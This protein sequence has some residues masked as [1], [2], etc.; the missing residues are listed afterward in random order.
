MPLRSDVTQLTV[1]QSIQ[2]C[3]DQFEVG[4][5][6]TWPFEQRASLDAATVWTGLLDEEGDP[7]Y[8]KH[9]ADGVIDEID[10]QAS[11]RQMVSVIRG[12]DA[13]AVA[14][15]TTFYIE[16]GGPPDT[17]T[18]TSEGALAPIPGVTTVLRLPGKWFASAI[19]RDL[20]QRIGLDL[21]W[22]VP[23]YELKVPFSVSGPVINALQELAAPFSQFEPSRVDVWVEGKTLIMRSR[24]GLIDSPAEGATP[25]QTFTIQSLMS[26]SLHLRHSTL[27]QTRVLRLTGAG[28]GGGICQSI[29][30]DSI[31]TLF[32]DSTG[33]FITTRIVERTTR[34]DP[35]GAILKV[36][37]ETY[38]QTPGAEGQEALQTLRL[39]GLY[40][41]IA[42]WDTLFFDEDCNLLNTPREHGQKITIE[43]IDPDETISSLQ[44][45][46]EH[47]V[48][49]SYDENGFRTGQVTEKF[50][51]NKEESRFDPLAKEVTR[52]QPKGILEYEQIT[53]NYTAGENDWTLASS[54]KSPA[55]GHLP[56]GPGRA[57]PNNV[58][59]RNPAFVAEIIDN[60]PGARDFTYSNPNL[61][62]SQLAI[63]RQQAVDASGA[64]ELEVTFRASGIPWLRKG[65][66]IRIK[67]L[68]N[69]DNDEILEAPLDTFL[70][71]A[72]KI[73]LVESRDGSSYVSQVTAVN[74]SGA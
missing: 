32:F 33:S 67:G 48:T 19:A 6:G 47:T 43:A 55:G 69:P 59:S 41:M 68:R 7:Q 15:D 49:F 27:P 36:V 1:D 74:W 46:E 52:L 8:V 60:V 28:Q 71:T 65:Q 34:R 39:S 58:L 45:V 13:S 57:L 4:I 5:A 18:P 35:D 66:R 64:L 12:R 3:A 50:V 51:W 14:I 61:T 21:S 25:V 11:S 2:L 16:Y 70:V 56:A 42:N 24:A 31:E 38:T 73:T 53:D 30:E 63:I 26:Q 37:K 10:L 20:T 17:S 29:S 22:H 54:R 72:N 9:I 44:P 23:D 40:K 62:E